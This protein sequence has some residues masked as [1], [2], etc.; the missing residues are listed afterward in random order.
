VASAAGISHHP[1]D[2]PY[3][4]TPRVTLAGRTGEVLT[5]NAFLVT[6]GFF[7]TVRATILEGREIVGRD[8]FSSP[9]VVVVNETAARRYW[10]GQDAIG[11]Q[12]IIDAGPDER[13]REVVGVVKDLA[14]RTRQTSAEPVLYTSYLQQPERYRGRF[15]GMF[16]QMTFVVRSSGDPQAVVREA[17]YAVVREDGS[18]A[19][20]NVDLNGERFGLPIREFRRYVVVLSLFAAIAVLLSAI[21]IY[22]VIALGVAE[23]TREIAIRRAV[24]ADRRAIVSIVWRQALPMVAGGIGLGL[25]GAVGLT[26]WLRSQLWGVTPT[27][28]ATLVAVAAIVVLASVAACVCPVRRALAVDPKISLASE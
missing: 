5:P 26:G 20:T 9:W 3:L 14:I 17:Q 21:G 28:P 13:A 15:A 11:Q 1:L 19:L 2:T 24:G 25:F 12:L 8:T 22:G 6:P 16:G 10:P 27:D 4:P 7:S 23:R 18:R